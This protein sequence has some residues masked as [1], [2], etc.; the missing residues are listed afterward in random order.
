MVT[1]KELKFLISLKDFVKENPSL[2]AAV[3]QCIE[4]GMTDA[5]KE[6]SERAADMET[7]VAMALNT[8][9]FKGNETFIADKL[10]K[11]NGRSALKWDAQ[12]EALTKRSAK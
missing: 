12:I 5:L 6:S 3:I 11:W 7:I 9:M 10:K 2:V 4:D 1:D 8:R